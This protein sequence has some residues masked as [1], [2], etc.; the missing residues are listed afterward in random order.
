V[1]ATAIVVGTLRTARDDLV[2]KRDALNVAIEE[3]DSLIQ[4]RSNSSTGTPATTTGPKRLS[5]PRERKRDA[6]RSGATGPTMKDVIY[7]V[8]SGSPVPVRAEFVESAVISHGWAASSVR[9]AL[10]S[11]VDD[12][13]VER[14]ARG[15]FSAVKAD[16]SSANDFGPASL[17]GPKEANENESPSQGG[18]LVG[19]NGTSLPVG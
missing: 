19:A 12:G 2:A 1:D 16:D 17:A 11:L 3:L 5:A 13:R 4:S 6:T 9:K 15:L 8:I 18:V 7:T 10:S 14:V